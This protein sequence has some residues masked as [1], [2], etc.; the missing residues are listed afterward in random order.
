MRGEVIPFRPG[1]LSEATR[2]AQGDKT[3]RIEPAAE[4]TIRAPIE[5]RWSPEEVNILVQ[6]TNNL[7]QSIKALEAVLAGMPAHRAEALQHTIASLR[8]DLETLVSKVP[9]MSDEVELELDEADLEEPLDIQQLIASERQLEPYPHPS[10]PLDIILKEPTA[11]QRQ[12]RLEALAER[13]RPVRIKLLEDLLARLEISGS[14]TERAEVIIPAIQ[15]VAADLGF[16]TNSI[17][18]MKKQMAQEL[19]RLRLVG[20]TTNRQ[21]KAPPAEQ[22]AAEARAAAA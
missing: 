4:Q 13:D 3:Q 12:A 10:V 14:L 21:M 15:E 1:G 2:P 7:Q 19:K 16:D 5:Q 9:D 22:D 17:E 11:K 18:K 8:E 6:E 20:D